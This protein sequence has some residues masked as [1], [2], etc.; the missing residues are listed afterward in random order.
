MKF[1]SSFLNSHEIKQKPDESVAD[2]V[3]RSSRLM[4]RF[5]LIQTEIAWLRVILI[6]RNS[7]FFQTLTHSPSLHAKEC[8]PSDGSRI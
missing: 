8:Q 5:L 2:K 7:F 6:L 4:E 3:E 1:L